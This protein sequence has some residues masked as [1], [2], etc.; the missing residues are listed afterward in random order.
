MSTKAEVGEGTV[1]LSLKD[2]SLRLGHNQIL[3]KV[4]FE[5]KNRRRPNLVTGQIVG[6]L[7]PSG[8]GKTR[9]IRLISG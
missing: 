5:V 1:L 7:G 9:I 4:S 3:E 8:V 6:L 2:V